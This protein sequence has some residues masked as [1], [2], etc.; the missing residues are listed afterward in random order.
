[1]SI[2]RFFL[3]QHGCAKNQVDGEIIIGIL[4]AL[5]WNKTDTAETADLIIIN[6]CGF[7]EPAKKESIEAVLNARIAYPNAK[8]LLAGCLAER[9]GTSLQKDL[10][11]SDAFF[12]NGDLS[13]LPKIIDLLYPSSQQNY[14]TSPIKQKKDIKPFIKP[15]QHGV[16]SGARPYILNFPRSA[17]I[18]ITEGCNNNCTFCAIPII[19]GSVRSRPILDIVNEIQE[20]IKKG[21][22]EFNLIGQDLAVFEVDIDST[23][24][25]PNRLS[26][27]AQLLSA[28]SRLQGI[29]WV[30]LLYIHPD[31]YPLDILPIMIQDNRFLPYFD[32]PFQSGSKKIIHAMN[33]RGNAQ[34]YLNLVKSIKTAFSESNNPY[35]EAV[36]R[37]TFLTGF[38]GETEEDFSETLTFLKDIQSLWSGVF[39]YSKE[40]GTQ[41]AKIKPYVSKKIAEQRK[42]ILNDIQTTITNTMLHRFYGKKFT[43]LIEEIFTHNDKDEC[44]MALGRAWFQAPEVDGS[45]VLNFAKGQLDSEGSPLAPGSFIKVRITGIHG[46]DLEAAAV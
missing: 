25:T 37:T 41:A 26:G 20:F 5:G 31:H 8:I 29:F 3:D 6:S 16:C 27:L 39:T 28:I 22:K 34:I 46:I 10:P 40:D 38:P 23:R 35:G 1:M 42:K 36:I 13:Q 14:N 43:V 7:I 2:K 18:K 15:P 12:G 30:R 11:E 4:N 33:R 9:Y 21:Y 19:R 44:Y 24:D 45:V 32:I 17:F